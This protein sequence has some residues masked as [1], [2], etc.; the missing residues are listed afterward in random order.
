MTAPSKYGNLYLNRPIFSSIASVFLSVSE[1]GTVKLWDIETG[2]CL[3]SLNV[4]LGDGNH[5][6][7]GFAI[8]PDGRIVTGDSDVS[9]TAYTSSTIKIWNLEDSSSQ[10]IGTVP[11][12][13]LRIE[14][15]GNGAYLAVATRKNCE[16]C[17][18]TA[19]VTYDQGSIYLYF[20]NDPTQ[21][22]VLGDTGLSN[23]QDLSDYPEYFHTEGVFNLKPINDSLFASS[24]SDYTVKV[25]NLTAL[26]ED[27]S[28]GAPLTLKCQFD[29]VT[30][31]DYDKEAQHLISG[32]FDGLIYI[33]SMKEGTAQ[34]GNL[35][36]S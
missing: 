24:S 28:T 23:D 27:I 12:T 11:T 32:S 33:Y 34:Y 25:W 31:L 35:L 36:G 5:M 18:T 3:A 2:D 4:T 10:L 15:V 20:L 22:F 17:N 9:N 30:G 29:Y 21:F 26:F 19:S 13:I 14:V 1:D 6:I 8:L 7:L 16:I